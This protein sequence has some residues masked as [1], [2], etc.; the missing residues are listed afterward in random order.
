MD[1]TTEIKEYTKTVG[2]F[3]TKSWGTTI[4]LAGGGGRIFYNKTLYFNASN[5]NSI[6]GKSIS[7]QPPA[8]SLI[9]QIR[10]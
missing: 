8:L 10:F 3:S 2:A 1:G 5:S 7:V 9:P 6:Y 4:P